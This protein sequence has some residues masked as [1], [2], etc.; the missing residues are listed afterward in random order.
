M[1]EIQ[2]QSEWVEKIHGWSVEDPV[3]GGE[4]GVDNVP[5][6]ELANR[7]EYLKE[8]I[9]SVP[10]WED[11]PFELNNSLGSFS[12]D[13]NIKYNKSLGLLAVKF[14]GYQASLSVNFIGGYSINIASYNVEEAPFDLSNTTYIPL[15][16]GIAGSLTGDQFSAALLIAGGVI[17][18]RVEWITRSTTNNS[19]NN[20]PLFFV[21]NAVIPV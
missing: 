14:N 11:V 12:A 6:G 20:L 8:E 13:L 21:I 18:F 7:T 5:I 4:T 2:S 16:T 3:E 9:D 15:R 1:F 17:D 19:S 10:E